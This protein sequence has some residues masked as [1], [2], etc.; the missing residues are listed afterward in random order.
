[1]PSGLKRWQVA[2]VSM[3]LIRQ[4]DGARGPLL[5]GTG[6]GCRVP[7][8]PSFWGPGRPAPRPIPAHPNPHH[9]PSQ[10][11]HPERRSPR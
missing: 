2:L 7:P 3:T 9:P 10:P 6:A 5:L 4:T 8:V 11:R 1:M